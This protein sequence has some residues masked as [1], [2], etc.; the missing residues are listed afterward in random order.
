MFAIFLLAGIGDGRARPQARRVGARRARRGDEQQHRQGLGRHR[1]EEETGAEAVAARGGVGGRT[2]H[3]GD[4]HGQREETHSTGQSPTGCYGDSDVDDDDDDDDGGDVDDDDVD[5]DDDDGHGD[6]DNY[7]TDN[8]NDDVD[9]VDVDDNVDDDDEDVDDD[10]DSDGDGD[11]GGGDGDH[12][13]DD[14]IA[15]FL[16]GS[17]GY[18]LWW[19][20][21]YNIDWYPLDE[22]VQEMNT[23]QSS[24]LSCLKG[25]HNGRTMLSYIQ[26]HI[27]CSWKQFEW[28]SLKVHLSAEIL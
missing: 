16:E 1:G 9:D 21:F 15:E 5:G 24:K 27:F 7:D 2:D 11:G 14:E 20:C 19:L 17:D 25:I 10:V 12:G 13:A 3:G 23:E 28:I 4:P 18:E 22:E 6:G 8:V 26:E